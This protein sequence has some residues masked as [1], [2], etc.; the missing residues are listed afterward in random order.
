MHGLE[1]EALEYGLFIWGDGRQP[2]SM[3]LY[4]VSSLGLLLH[5]TKHCS[6]LEG[7]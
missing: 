2:C 1:S 4:G 5:R 7:F 3:D 6:F